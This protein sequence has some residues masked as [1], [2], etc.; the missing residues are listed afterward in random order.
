MTISINV[1]DAVVSRASTAINLATNYQTMVPNP[2]YTPL[3]PLDPQTNPMSI[4]NPVTPLAWV[5]Q[6]IINYLV[7]LVQQG[8]AMALKTAN[9]QAIVNNNANIAANINLT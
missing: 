1:P 4:A 9:D 5:K 8:E 6:I 2:A 7:T 3:L